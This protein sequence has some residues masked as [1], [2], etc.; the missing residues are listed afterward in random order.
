MEHKR[1]GGNV[2]FQVIV[3]NDAIF[4]GRGHEKEK[5]FRLSMVESWRERNIQIWQEQGKTSAPLVMF[6]CIC[7]CR[8]IS[9]IISS[10][11][12][13]YH[14]FH[15]GK[16]SE[17]TTIRGILVYHLGRRGMG[18]ILSCF[19]LKKTHA[20]VRCFSVACSESLNIF[21]IRYDILY[22]T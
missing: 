12:K 7:L 15:I 1:S 22:P 5:G 21:N 8:P 3:M 11:V 13:G 20:R 9:D 16:K 2:G 10:D 6:S 17:N 4:V 19:Q 18:Q 14:L